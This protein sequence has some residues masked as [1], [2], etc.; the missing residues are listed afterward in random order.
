MQIVQEKFHENEF[1]KI[2]HVSE[3]EKTFILP[4][5]HP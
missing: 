3:Y 2:L 1:F 4:G 5:F